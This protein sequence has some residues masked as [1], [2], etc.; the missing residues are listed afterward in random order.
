MEM[1]PAAANISDEEL[2][3]R[4]KNARDGQRFRRLWRGDTSEYE[5]DH[6][7][8]DLALCRAL[9]FWCGG[10]SESIDRLFRR[11]G[12]MREKW[13]RRTGATAYGALTIRTALVQRYRTA[14][15]DGRHGEP[16]ERGDEEC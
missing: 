1:L 5:N 4:A 2:I 7:R 6:S 13:D 3:E 14:A 12:L 15:N 8:A 11:S 10:N 9:A 16:R